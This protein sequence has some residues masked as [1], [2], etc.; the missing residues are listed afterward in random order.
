LDYTPFPSLSREKKYRKENKEDSFI[1][2]GVECHKMR[3]QWVNNHFPPPD[4]REN[5]DRPHI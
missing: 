4:L 3:I 5:K 2:S 1:Y